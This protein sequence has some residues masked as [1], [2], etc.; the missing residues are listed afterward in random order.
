M[1]AQEFKQKYLC[2]HKALYRVAYHAT[3]NAMDAE[4]LL[5]DFYLKLW[6]KRDK[7]PPEA[8]NEGYLV[9]MMRNLYCDQLRLKRVDAS[10]DVDAVSE[11]PNPDSLERQVEVSDEATRVR[12]KIETLPNNE[13]MIVRM[14]VVEDRDYDEICDNTGLTQSNIRKI[15]SRAKIKLREM[16]K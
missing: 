5:Q 9:K 8:Q 2:F 13:R 3:G 4:D 1:T 12:S 14:R 10:V 7:L 11:P 16:L 15:V 6:T